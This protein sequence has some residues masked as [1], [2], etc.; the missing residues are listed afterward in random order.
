MGTNDFKSGGQKYSMWSLIKHENFKYGK[1][2]FDIA[3][4]QVQGEIEFNKMV[5]PIELSPK[6]IPVG[7][8]AQFYGWGDSKV[9]KILFQ[10][11]YS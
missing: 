2:Y 7:T 11:L 6:E 8:I 4:M 1:T 3:M 9:S 5:Q 10:K